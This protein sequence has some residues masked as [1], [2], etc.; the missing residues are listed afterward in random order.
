[1]KK[2][3][4]SRVA[5]HFVQEREKKRHTLWELYAKVDEAVSRS[6]N[7]LSKEQL[8]SCADC[9]WLA[10]KHGSCK[11]SKGLMLRNVK[12][13]SDLPTTTQEKLSHLCQ[14]LNMKI[15]TFV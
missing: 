14:I 3:R 4:L 5:Q 8:G 15:D 2:F 7:V 9:M 1:M 12:N 11:E 13:A 6:T 10:R